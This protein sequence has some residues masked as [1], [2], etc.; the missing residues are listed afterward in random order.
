VRR[1]L[2]GIL[3]CASLVS[4]C[5]LQPTYVRPEAKVPNAWPRGAAYAQQHDEALPAVRYEDVFRDAKLRALIARGLENNQSLRAAAATVASARAQYHVQRADLF[6]TLGAQAG[7]TFGHAGSASSGAT[8]GGG[9]AGAGTGSGNYERYSVQLGIASY[10]LDLFGKLRSEKD[11]ALES[12]FATEAGAR[13]TRLA[14]VAQIATE[15]LTLAA[16]K[17]LLEVAKRTVQNAERASSLIEARL[18]GG[19]S[20][21][22]DLSQAKTVLAQAQADIARQT[23]A[24]AQHQNALRLLVGAEIPPDDLPESLEAVSGELGEV[25]AG[26]SSEVLLRR[27][28]V[29]QAELQLKSANARI[30]VARA[31]FFPTISLT[32][33][34]GF[35]S[36]SLTN[37]FSGGFGWSVGP[38]ATVPI[39]DFGKN[40]GNLD[41]AKAQRELYLARYQGAIQTAFREVADALARRGTIAQELGARQALVSAANDSFQLSEARYRGGVDSFLNNLEAQRTLYGAQRS[42]IATELDRAT[43]LVTLYQ[44]LGGDAFAGQPKGTPAPAKR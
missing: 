41:F 33:L 6:P 30:G 36:G 9:T 23:A 25:P 4:A 43:N 28:D 11:A 32:G 40:E 31:A 29:L 20:S 5:S 39:F 12:Y 24:V 21:K 42:L 19:V 27:P 13:A 16:D 34:L 37:L 3:G 8:A 15:Y 14:L 44:V 18:A 10:E 26:L 2:L 17:S 22:L 1:G 38:S 35:A 7:A